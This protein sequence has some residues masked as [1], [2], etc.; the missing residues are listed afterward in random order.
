M[1]KKQQFCPHSVRVTTN[2]L[3]SCYHPVTHDHNYLKKVL[4]GYI[5]IR[6]GLSTS[7]SKS[8]LLQP[9]WAPTSGYF[10]P[11]VPTATL[12][13]T[14]VV[15]IQRHPYMIT[16]SQQRCHMIYSVSHDILRLFIYRYK[17]VYVLL[18]HIGLSLSTVIGYG[19]MIYYAVYLSL[20]ICL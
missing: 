12:N 19:H 5:W 14:P 13:P 6:V 10:I 11:D 1:L 8:H 4:R 17:S 2:G 7:W 20:K 9:R 3:S 15:L 18:L 16:W